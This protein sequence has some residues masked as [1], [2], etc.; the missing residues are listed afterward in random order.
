MMMEGDI[1]SWAGKKKDTLKFCK[2]QK[3]MHSHKHEVDRQFYIYTIITLII[4]S[5]STSLTF[6]TMAVQ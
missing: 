4:L 6:K 2:Y 3:H 1:Y 5:Y